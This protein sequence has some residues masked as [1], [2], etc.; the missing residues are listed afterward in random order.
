MSATE[1]N[2]AHQIINFIVFEMLF[3]LALISHLK[4]MLTNPG[5]VPKGFFFSIFIYLCLIMYLEMF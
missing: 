1:D 5:T 4:T 2:I 3:I